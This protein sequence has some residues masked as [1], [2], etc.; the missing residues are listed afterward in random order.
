MGAHSRAIEGIKVE[1]HASVPIVEV[2]GDLDLHEVPAFDAAL[3]H[4]AQSASQEIIVSL[5]ETTYFN[6]SGIRAIMRLAAHLE[7][8][9]RHL[10]LVAP[11][12]RVPRRLLD[13]VY[14]T[15]DLLPFESIEEALAAVTN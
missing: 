14:L 9:N 6:S 8:E 11:H 15:S 13:I 12:D 5:A 2:I 4:A 10:L 7:Q 3:R 1:M